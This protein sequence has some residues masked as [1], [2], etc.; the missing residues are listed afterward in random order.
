[1]YARSAG[2]SEPLEP[3]CRRNT[4]APPRSSRGR[5]WCTKGRADVFRIRERTRLKKLAKAIVVV[6]LVDVFLYWFYLTGHRFSLPTFGPDSIVFLPV[7]GIFL[8][9][10]LDGAAAAVQ[11]SLAAHDRLPRAGRA[12]A[13]RDQG[14]RHAGRRGRPLARR[15]PRLRDVP[16]RARGHPPPRHP[17][18]G[19]A[20]DRQDV[21]RQ[22]DGQA[23]RGAVP[24]HPRARR[25]RRCGRACPRGAS[26]RSSRSSARPPARKGVRSG[27]SRRST[28][29]RCG[30]AAPCGHD[31]GARRCRRA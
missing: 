27:S 20:G 16:R 19:P 14:P 11:R 31:A 4:T 17:V 30:E 23:G 9:I 28:R 3:P 5:T 24:V 21:P 10:L 26:A 15:L 12:R 29:S 6:A 18:R 8:A 2:P 25:S 13:H 1:M 7:I 22:G